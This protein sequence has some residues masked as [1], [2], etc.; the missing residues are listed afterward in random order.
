MNHD[1]ATFSHTI[2]LPPAGNG[3]QAPCE[4]LI[5]RLLTTSVVLAEDWD[6]L[7]QRVQRRIL[8]AKDES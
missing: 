1:F 2:M 6:A 7:P 5:N 8:E 4:K 3:N